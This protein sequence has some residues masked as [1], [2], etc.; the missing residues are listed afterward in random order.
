M[1][2]DSTIIKTS[3][4]RKCHFYWSHLSWHG[5]KMPVKPDNAKDMCTAINSV[6]IEHNLGDQE[7]QNH[8]ENM[9][10]EANGK[11]LPKEDLEWFSYKDERLCF[12]MWSILR[13]LVVNPNSELLHGLAFNAEQAAYQRPY[14]KQTLNLRP[15]TRRER[16]NLIINFFDTCLAP[17]DRQRALLNEL[18]EKWDEVYSIEKFLKPNS[19][20]EDYGLWLWKYVTTNEEFSIPHWFIPVPKKPKDM[21]DS[22]IAAFDAWQAE[23]Y[24][25]KF[26][27]VRMKK[28]WSQKKHRMA[29]AKKNKK[30]YNFTLTTTTKSLL[31]EMANT[32]GY[33]RN[34]VLE[35]LIKLGHHKLNSGEEIL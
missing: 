22:A 11:L 8:V 5:F 14:E 12:W 18:R 16:Y 10:N 30:S 6:L 2:N 19:S 34:E 20:E 15:L 35:R 24:E 28:A 3:D 32:T 7:T 4:L 17:I 25:K 9:V 21:Y 29:I 33:S 26:F 31:D 13:L 23:A 27:I 1:T